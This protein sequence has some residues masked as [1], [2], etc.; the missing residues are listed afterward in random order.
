[1]NKLLIIGIDGADWEQT[2]E[3][4]SAGGLPALGRL[5]EEGTW[6][7]LRSTLPPVSSPAWATMTTG[8]APARLG[9]FDLTVPDGYGK[10]I[11]NANDVGWPRLWDYVGA[12]GGS[13]VIVNVPVTFPPRPMAGT[14]VC[15]F[16]SPEDAD[17]TYPTAVGE[18][19][20]RRFGYR[21]G[22]PTSQRGK[23]REV[24]RRLAVT[25]FLLSSRPWDL[26]MV[27]FSATDWA[28]HD[29]WHDRRYVEDL[30]G[31]VSSAVGEIIEAAD[32]ENVAVVS[33]HGFCGAER[34]L[35]VNRLLAE[36]GF[37][38]YG[39]GSGSGTYAPNPALVKRGPGGGALA[40][41]LR[42]I[43]RPRLLLGAVHRLGLDRALNIVPGF[44]WRAAKSGLEVWDTP[45]DWSRTR[46][47]L[48][49]GLPQTIRI[50]LAGREP[51]GIVAPDEY[52]ALCGE[53]VSRFQDFAD[54]LDG[55]RIFTRVLRREEAF[56]GADPAV[57]PDL[58]FQ[59]RDDAYL[60]SPADHP[61][62][63]WRT[64]RARGRHRER[65]IYVLQGP[66]FRR[67]EGPEARLVDMTPTL[68]CAMG[69]AIP[70]GIDGRPA[71]D[72][73]APGTPPAEQTDYGLELGQAG[74][75]EDA[76]EVRRR[77]R[78]LGYI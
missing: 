40:G 69:L 33:D 50:N 53:L 11:V 62:V 52:D 71:E 27:V 66:A 55:E 4:M 28:Q 37:L 9:V 17:Y 18:E 46:A 6:G 2:S 72:L 57:A 8:V 70:T 42:R 61:Q 56:P 47:Y 21:P 12:N 41:A 77:L 44:L 74:T 1:V 32:A 10:R 36:L 59:V 34:I 22:H 23:L 64:G 65:G 35:N 5:A 63:V 30:F 60:V 49:N 76:P 31:E 54:P 15:G 39:E 75:P 58:V 20:T 43:V 78:D 51:E 38:R 19:L 24:R 7:P 73:L 48:Y 68:L 25:L 29:H 67:G 45:I 26:A 3:W 16:L 13:S 14:L